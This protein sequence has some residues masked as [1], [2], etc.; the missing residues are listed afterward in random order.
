ME[1]GRAR[2]KRTEPDTEHGVARERGN[3]GGEGT[4]KEEE[5]EEDRKCSLS[6]GA[7]VRPS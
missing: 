2:G 6:K 4:G 3:R 1:N 5:Q 7:W